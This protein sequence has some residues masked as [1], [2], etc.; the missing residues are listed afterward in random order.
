VVVVQD[1]SAD[2]TLSPVLSV[3]SNLP[4][5]STAETQAQEA[6]LSIYPANA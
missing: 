2:H 6:V 3:I 1:N 5:S 4:V